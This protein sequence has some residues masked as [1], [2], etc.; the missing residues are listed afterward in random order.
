MFE[1]VRTHNK[2]FF[3][4]LMPLVFVS[5][6]FVGVQ[7]YDRM[8]QG[9]GA[10]VARVDGQ[11]IT[12]AE[13]DAAHRRQVDQARSRMPDMDA[14]FFDSPEVKREA[15]DQMVRD[16]VLFAAATRGHLSV[17]NERLMREIQSIPQLAALKRPDGSFD[18]DAYKAMVQAS[19]RSAESFEAGLRQDLSVRQVLTAIDSS[20]A[21]ASAAARTALDALLQQREVQV[22]RFDSKDQTAGITPTDAELAAY[23][24]ANESEFRAPEQAQVEYV[25]LDIDAIAARVSAPEDELRKFYEQNIARYTVAEERRASHI[26][27]KA[28]KDAPAA[29]RQKAKAK[30][31]AL[32]AQ[33]RKAPATF[34]DVAKKNSEDPGSAER[35]GDLD[36]FGRGAMV[37]PFEDAAYAMKAGEISNVVESDFGYHVIRLDAVRGGEK[38]PFEAARAEIE[39]EVKK[40]LAAK[41]FA[42]DAER[43]T[44]L[45]NKD[46]DSFKSVVS[47]LKLKVQTASALRVP[48]PGAKGAIASPKLLDAVFSAESIKNKQ[49]TEAIEVGPNQL[50]SARLVSYTPARV[51]ALAEVTAQVHERVVQQQAAAKAKKAGE[52]KLAAV[53]AAD[54]TAGLPAAVLLSR[55]E[56]AGQP[57]Q[58]VEAVLKADGAKLPQWLGVDLGAAGYA[59]VRL[60]AVKNRAPDAPEVAQLM[61]RYGQA[62]AGAESQA[63]YKALERRFKVKIDVAAAAAA[64]SAPASN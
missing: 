33:L 1:Y 17:S 60:N 27:I 50:A 58:V 59:V 16:R 52:D 30:A 62:W 32:L 19:G 51:Q 10:E 7:G 28:P 6:V 57:R 8:S 37:K 29:D 45:V 55:S 38:K 11:K 53:K 39:A 56:P 18:V 35:G 61:P 31:D 26:L 36:F 54:S 46:T 40:Q 44:N 14:K 15:L 63:Y 22:L 21:P 43:F 2:I 9:A 49:N 47:D 20:A 13:W 25:V 42:A 3:L 41:E 5:F 12:Q 23:H 64:A 34:A 4:I 48:A 24:K